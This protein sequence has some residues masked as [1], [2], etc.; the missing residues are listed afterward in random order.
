MRGCYGPAMARIILALLAALLFLPGPAMAA[1]PH[2]RVALAAESL[3]PRP[4]GEVA[5]AVIMTPQPGWHGYWLNT[6]DA[7]AADRFRWTLPPGAALSPLQYPPPQRLVV[8]GLMNYVYERPYALLARLKV[9]DGIAPGTPLNLAATVD[10]LVCS[11]TLCVPE[12]AQVM[13]RLKAGDGAIAASSRARFDQWRAALPRPLGSPS[14]FAM[15]GGTLRLAVPL[16]TIDQVRSAYFYPAARDVID[17]AAPQK[18]GIYDNGL[19]VETAR[20]SGRPLARAVDG[21]LAIDR[22]S[23]SIA[24]AISA[25]PGP[26]PTP[27]QWLTGNEPLALAPILLILLAAIAGGLILNAMPCVFPILSLKALSLARSGESAS[28]ARREALA[29]AAGVIVT[30]LVLGGIMLAL[31]AAGESAGWAFQLQNPHIILLLLLLTAAIGLNLAGLFELP[32]LSLDHP[33]SPGNRPSGAFL[34]G[35]LAAFVATPCT[36]PFMGAALGSALIL[37]W[38]A[39]LGV[40]AGL[41]IG[42]ALPFIAIAHVPALRNRLPRPGP[43]MERFRRVM[44]VPMLLTALA[45]LWVLGRQTG[46]PGIALAVAAVLLLAVLLFW[47]GQR[48]KRGR[49]AGLAAIALALAAVMPMLLIGRIATPPDSRA[50]RLGDEAFSETR[51]AT[52]RRQGRPAFVYFTADWCLTC[53]VNEQVAINRRPVRDAFNRAGIVTLVGDWTNGDPAITRFLEKHGRNGV[54]L[55]LFYPKDGS[56]PA[57]LP[58]VLTVSELTALAG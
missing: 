46:N 39:A 17:H 45:L 49:R 13:L 27:G 24:L 55:Y 51:L 43:W 53:K 16:A 38:P 10:Y 29:Y 20:K 30:C 2:M 28:A 11:D 19:V 40:F 31:R 41:G 26:V 22:P 8:A 54:P 57:V 58:Q 5:I 15:A 48:Q 33:G 6:G 47:L 14:Y 4:G 21:V 34:T 23:G 12:Q 9:A 3:T 1:E 42:L 44:A 50:A 7:G 32:S 35:V 36:G 52:L 56:P 25:T 37:P 18:V